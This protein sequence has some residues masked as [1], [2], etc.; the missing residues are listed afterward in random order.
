MPMKKQ[1][2][3]NFYFLSALL[4]TLFIY[5]QGI[6]GPFLLDDFHNLSPLADNGGIVNYYNFKQ[7]VFGNNSGALGRSVSMLSFVIDDQAWPSETY[8]FKYTNIF[9]HLLVGISLFIFLNILKQSTEYQLKLSTLAILTCF[10]IW[11]I[12]PLNQSTVLYV[13]QRMTELSTLFSLLALSCYIQAKNNSF[14]TSRLYLWLFGFSICSIL[15]LF[16]KENGINI[17]LYALV[18]ELTL[19]RNIKTSQS[20]KYIKIIILYIPLLILA[21]YFDVFP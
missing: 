4:I 19:L 10:F 12:H 8:S 2:Y 13:I 1:F 16:S 6:S 21:G 15:A 18:L 3:I 11:L 7:F 17:L 9:I 5:W 20:W 14:N